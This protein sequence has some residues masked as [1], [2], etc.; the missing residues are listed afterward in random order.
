MSNFSRPGT[1]LSAKGI[2]RA[3]TLTAMILL[4]FSFAVFPRV[5]AK[6]DHRSEQSSGLIQ[7]PA[8]DSDRNE[9]GVKKSGI[10]D[11][12]LLDQ[13][14]K[15]ILFYSQML[16]GKVV[17]INF[18][19]TTCAAFCAAQGAT[20]AKL[21][22]LLGGDLGTS[23]NLITIT[24]DPETDTPARLKSWSEKFK[25][26]PGWTMVTGERKAVDEILK[27]LTGDIGRT[28]MHSPI[29]L[30]GDADKGLWIRDY[31]LADPERLDAM[32]EQLATGKQ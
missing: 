21:Q 30:I 24:T 4:M 13:D 12:E 3:S 17:A 2:T 8:Q 16:R 18:V 32:I 23:V 19:Y 10:P 28:G 1:S 7:S 9:A 14:G 15:R 11:I 29:V 22:E 5:D 31:G 25:V 20:F 27:A 6:S 26:K